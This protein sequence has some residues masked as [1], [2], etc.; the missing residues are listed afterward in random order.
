MLAGIDDL[1]F[2]CYNFFMIIDEK[3]AEKICD[4]LEPNKKLDM[5]AYKELE[6]LI[7]NEFVFYYIVDKLFSVKKTKKRDLNEEIA[8]RNLRSKKVLSVLETNEDYEARRQGLAGIN[9]PEEYIN[10]IISKFNEQKAKEQ[11][12]ES[13]QKVEKLLEQLLGDDEDSRIN[14]VRILFDA[15]SSALETPQLASLVSGLLNIS[16][17]EGNMLIDLYNKK[18]A[19]EILKDENVLC[20]ASGDKNIE[21]MIK[22]IT[23]RL[24]YKEVQTE[25]A[26]KIYFENKAKELLDEVLSLKAQRKEGL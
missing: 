6:K 2:Q 22:E 23:S 19:D 4:I 13:K 5:F 7:D 18:V 12:S 17:D 26:L 3:L 10:A 11:A 14:R 8:E 20:V 24:G 15:Y 25:V 16:Q 9:I 1:V 21:E